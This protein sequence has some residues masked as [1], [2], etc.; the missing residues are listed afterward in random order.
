M[1][2]AYGLIS[3]THQAY[4]GSSVDS[5]GTLPPRFALSPRSRQIQVSAR[6]NAEG[7]NR[8]APRTPCFR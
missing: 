8:L 3:L 7:K 2:L 1:S 4:R 6:P 5:R